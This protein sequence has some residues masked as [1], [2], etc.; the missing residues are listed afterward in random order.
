MNQIS[1]RVV[2]GE[3][4]DGQSYSAIQVLIDGTSLIDLAHRVEE[5][6]AKRE[7]HP[8]LAGAYAWLP[9]KSAAAALGL[10]AQSPDEKVAVLECACGVPGCWPLLAKI[11]GDENTVVWSEFEQPHR[12]EEAVAGHWKY[13]ALG[14]FSFD[15]ELYEEGLRTI[16]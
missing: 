13:E 7:G 11:S 4:E 12:N 1:L 14:P 2:S 6:F 5:P 8:K 3:L 15:R 16:A 9:R 10:R